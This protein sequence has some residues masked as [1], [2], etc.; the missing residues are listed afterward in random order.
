[1]F[2]TKYTLLAEKRFSYEKKKFYIENFF[3]EKRFF[4]AKNI[5]ENVKIYIS[6]LRNVC[7][8]NKI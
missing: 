7:V 8:T 4:T 5:N 3:T 1:M 2:F 6:H